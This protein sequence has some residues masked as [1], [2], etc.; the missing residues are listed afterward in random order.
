MITS[1]VNEDG[2]RLLGYCRARTANIQAAEDLFQE[3]FLKAFSFL[4]KKSVWITE[5]IFF[6][7]P[8]ARNLSCD[9]YREFMRKGGYQ[10]SIDELGDALDK[11][12]LYAN[13]SEEDERLELVLIAIEELPEW[14]QKILEDIVYFGYRPDE[15]AERDKEKITTIQ[16]RLARAR[17]ILREKVDSLMKSEKRSRIISKLK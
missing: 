9:K 11:L 17:S 16:G 7:I 1:W 15:I 14:A 4:K 10:A 5:P 8:I 3:T 12:A 13:H 2:K 6:L